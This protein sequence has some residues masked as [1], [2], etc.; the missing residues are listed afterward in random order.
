MEIERRCTCLSIFF[1][2]LPIDREPTLPPAEN[3]IPCENKV[4]PPSY[5]CFFLISLD[6]AAGEVESETR[7]RPKE[8]ILYLFS[9][10]YSYPPQATG[11]SKAML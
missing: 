11:G 3:P 2:P 8:L 10:P 6:L 5:V 9:S 4:E 1:F 7:Q